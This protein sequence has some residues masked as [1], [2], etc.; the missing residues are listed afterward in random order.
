MLGGLH[1]ESVCIR[2]ET[3]LASQEIPHPKSFKKDLS[4]RIRFTMIHLTLNKFSMI[5]KQ[6]IWSDWTLLIHTVIGF[7][8]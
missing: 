2:N 4:I 7:L 3:M 6:I 8:P 1:C 5:K